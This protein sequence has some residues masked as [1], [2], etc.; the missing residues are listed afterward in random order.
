MRTQKKS[1]DVRGPKMLPPADKLKALRERAK[2][3]GKGEVSAVMCAEAWRQYKAEHGLTQK[4]KKPKGPPSPNTWYRYESSAPDKQGDKP[5]PYDA[6]M[7]IMPMLVGRGIPPIE[8]DEL[9]ALTSVGRRFGNTAPRKAPQAPQLSVVPKTSL[10]MSNA[11][12]PAIH[13][14]DGVLPVKYRAERGTLYERSELDMRNFGQSN[15][16]ASGAVGQFAVFVGDDHAHPIYPSG[17]VLDCVECPDSLAMLRGKRVVAFAKR[18]GSDEIGQVIVANVEKVIG[19]SLVLRSIDGE[20]IDGD[21][22][23]LVRG[24]YSRD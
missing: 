24:H 9:M 21:V 2:T 4:G 14:S 12:L 20:I 10:P 16:I 8:E 22:L 19:E 13:A 7:A 18:A 11:T 23:G 5:I 17:S 1:T 15:L 3:D 6:V